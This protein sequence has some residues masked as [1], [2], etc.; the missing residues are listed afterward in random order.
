MLIVSLQLRNYRVFESLDLEFPPGVIGIY[1][2]NGAGKSTLLESILWVLYGK[3][4]T[5]KGEIR[6]ADAT[7]ECSAELLFEHDDHYYRARRSITGQNA[8]VKA[9]L[10]IG[11]QVA[12]DG[13]TEVEK[14]VHSLLGMDHS[15]F[16]AS[17][18]AEQKQLAAFSDQSPERRRQLVLQLLGITPLETARDAA[19]S[20][21]RQRQGDHQRLV[22]MLPELGR[23]EQR[24]SEA[25][26]IQHQAQL[27]AEQSTKH[28]VAADTAQNSMA[29]DVA[30]LEQ[31]RV[32][33]QLIRQQGA[34]VRD[35]R[36]RAAAEVARI[37]MEL[38]QL[39]V[40]R[41]RMVE[42]QQQA[43]ALAALE[44]R[45]VHLRAYD[46]AF[47]ELGS[48]PLVVVEEAPTETLIIEARREASEA[49]TAVALLKADSD[50][51]QANLEVAQRALEHTATL[52]DGSECPLCGQELG[53]GFATVHQHRQQELVAAQRAMSEV[54][55]HLPAAMLRA[56]DATC[57]LTALETAQR[58]AHDS[59]R[60]AAT[61]VAQRHAAE[62]GLHDATAA[63]GSQPTDQFRAELQAA[64]PAARTA[65]TEVARLLG[66]LEAEDSL[67]QRHH[68]E[69]GV[70]TAAEADRQ[71]LLSQL[72]NI[73]FVPAAYDELLERHR[74]HVALAQTSRA[75]SVAADLA[76]AGAGALLA[77]IQDQVVEARQQH[78]GV[79]ALADDARHLSRTADLLQGFRHLLVGLIGPR[80]SIQAGE[81]F[82]E[83]TGND[84]DGLTVDADTYE[85]RI[86][87]R[88]TSYP[89][90]RFSGSEIDLA[91]LALRV[92]ISEQVRFQAGGQVGLLVLDEALASL[93][94]DRKDRML[95]ALT[96]LGGRFRQ[97]LVVTHAP[98]VKEQLPQ[99]IEVL[100]TGSGKS[101]ARVVE[102]SW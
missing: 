22:S 33:H 44:E 49:V 88:G 65:S 71:R 74:T 53:E 52:G 45:L 73:A 68:D 77:A 17:V 81:L 67:R 95:T 50:R 93:D 25:T 13:P 40:D 41:A 31:A 94:A 37:N 58:R 84:Y 15:A 56:G 46:K 35:R 20:D 86:M 47:N 63:L 90:N 6:S 97:I 102:P 24:L 51:A 87:D 42:L 18:F 9:R 57:Q 11:D 23:L 96:R 99:A 21:A 72:A 101:T 10:W 76:L 14:F 98:E 2:P 32:Q 100:K 1:G 78:A 43:A 36:D 12:A 28:W 8:T 80:L 92:A 59:A 64:L 91:N 16:R 60:R 26:G 5:Q 3:A 62:Q 27:D 4:R 75:A 38:Q 30:A 70:V 29:S 39:V 7:G 55:N 61:A 89:T 66:R 48:Q 82:N 19:R 34:A 54:A 69:Q 85:L 79:G 83:L